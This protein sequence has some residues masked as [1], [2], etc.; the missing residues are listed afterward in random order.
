MFNNINF[1]YMENN[2]EIKKIDSS[3]VECPFCKNVIEAPSKPDVIF[4][5][6][7]CYKELITY[8]KSNEPTL[9]YSQNSTTLNCKNMSLIYCK[10]CGKQISDS[11]SN[12][13]FCGC[14]QNNIPSNNNEISLS[15]LFVSFLIPL[16]GLILCFTSWNRHEGK[17]KSALIGTLVGIIFTAILYSII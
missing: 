2:N 10:D 14:S 16:I 17:T 1:D 12:C 4:K 5:C 6:P 7:K 3:M 8:D 13:P 15:Y 11:A 9:N